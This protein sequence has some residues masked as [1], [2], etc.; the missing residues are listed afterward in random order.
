MMSAKD[1]A[2]VMI[3]ILAIVFLTR[4]D[5][6]AIKKRAVSEIQ[7]MHNLGKYL[8]S[9]ERIEWLRKKLQDVHRFPSL[10]APLRAGEGGSQRSPQ[11]EENILVDHHPKSLGE[12]DKADVDVL[13]KAKSQ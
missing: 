10:G 11:K 9:L 8:A 3:V 4:T 2:K 1:M 7:F 6:K 5:G 12:G 13:I